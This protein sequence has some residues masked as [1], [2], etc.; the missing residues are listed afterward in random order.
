MKSYQRDLDAF[1]DKINVDYA[2]FIARK[3]SSFGS[4]DELGFRTAGSDAEIESG[5]FLYDEF[6]NIGLEN[7]RKEKVDVDAWEFKHGNLYYLDDS[8]SAQ[9][10]ILNSFSSN[11]IHEN[12]QFELV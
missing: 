4:N 11:C 1:Y 12:K 7:V 3:L 9:K 6:I 2:T 5:D 10:L 8:Y